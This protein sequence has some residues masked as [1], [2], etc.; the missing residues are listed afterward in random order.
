MDFLLVVL[1]A[2]IVSLL[3]LIVAKLTSIIER[4][5]E[6]R[7]LAAENPKYI[8]DMFREKTVKIWQISSGPTH[9]SG[10][11][12][13]RVGS[14]LTHKNDSS[15]SSSPRSVER[16]LQDGAET[17]DFSQRILCSD[18]KCIGVIDEKG[19]CKVCGKPQ[20]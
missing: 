16:R 12:K 18:G 4:L 13:K 20:E 15:I 2:A 6:L 9:M 1:G 10:W 7:Y 11:M 17:I 3:F 8:G 14:D 5:D 19:F